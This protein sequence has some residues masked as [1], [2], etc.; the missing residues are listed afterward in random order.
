MYLNL[1]R[2][3]PYTNDQ[4]C[5]QYPRKVYNSLLYI[6]FFNYK[7]LGIFFVHFILD[8]V[9]TY[10][11]C[12]QLLLLVIN[13]CKFKYNFFL[14]YLYILSTKRTTSGMVICQHYDV[15]MSHIA[16]PDLLTQLLIE[17]NQ[18][19]QAKKACAENRG[20]IQEVLLL[21]VYALI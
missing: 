9:I 10:Y 17:F 19:S 5:L 18:M 2:I 4:Y 20:S 11:S 7:I 8:I 13:G 15:T 14:Y 16:W 3:M 21:S 12:P 6:S 1:F